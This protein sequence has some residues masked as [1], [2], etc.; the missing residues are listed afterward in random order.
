MRIRL[1]PT[2]S[3]QSAVPRPSR[4]AAPARSAAAAVEPVRD[5]RAASMVRWPASPTAPSLPAL[6][7]SP[8]SPASAASPASPHRL[9]TATAT[10]A[11]LDYDAMRM[12]RLR[13]ALLAFARRWGL[14]LATGLVVFGAGSNAPVAIGA[15]LVGALVWPLRHAAAHGLEIVPVVV[16]YAVVGA[17]PVLLSR[18]LWCPRGWAHAEHALPIDPADVRRSDRRFA[19]RVT[20]VWQTLL[21]AGAVG[22]AVGD[23]ATATPIVRAVAVVGWAAS[24][25]GSTMLS[26]AW[27]GW[28]RRRPRPTRRRM[29]TK[30]DERCRSNRVFVATGATRALVV[31]PLSRGRAPR[32]AA[33]FAVGVALASAAATSSRWSA[34]S[35]PWSLAAF[36]AIGLTTT[37]MLRAA[38][39]RELQPL[40]RAPRALPIDTGRCER[41]RLA[42]VLLPTVVGTIAAALSAATVAGVRPGAVAAFAATI[43]VASAIE[44]TTSPTMPAQDRA[45]RWVLLLAAALACAS[46]TLPG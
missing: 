43:A 10:L 40:W 32:S 37:G 2:A 25:A 33:T 30:V 13:A 18:T 6:P 26:V 42:V 35:L 14:Y 24:F 5:A 17:G 3:S 38:T 16:G 29:S 31:A 23:S 27:M 34:A 21:A 19:W 39:L 12:L 28:V 1:V 8:A 36:A 11:A 46:E 44:A 41:A 22:L 15:A 7:A 4:V 45:A 20:A 9:A